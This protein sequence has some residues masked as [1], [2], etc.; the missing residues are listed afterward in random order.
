MDGWIWRGVHLNILGTQQLGRVLSSVNRGLGSLKLSY[1]ECCKSG[2]SLSCLTCKVACPMVLLR[3]GKGGQNIVFKAKTK[4]PHISGIMCP[5]YDILSMILLNFNRIRLYE[6]INSNTQE[7]KR[8][9]RKRIWSHL[10]LP[11]LHTPETNMQ[12]GE[13]CKLGF[14]FKNWNPGLFLKE[15]INGWTVIQIFF[16]DCWLFGAWI[17]RTAPIGQ[18]GGL[19]FGWWLGSRNLF[20]VTCFSIIF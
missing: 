13:L 16:V 12:S 11:I 18:I 5:T 19:V 9:V 10:A 4:G 20:S 15:Q 6:T 8:M 2:D 1:P 3:K 17:G 7:P 14:I